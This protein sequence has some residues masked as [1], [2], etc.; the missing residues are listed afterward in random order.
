MPPTFLFQ[1]QKA[2]TFYF[3]HR[4]TQRQNKMSRAPNWCHILMISILQRPAASSWKC[5]GI[6]KNSI[7]FPASSAHFYHSQI[8]YRPFMPAL[9]FWGSVS[10]SY[11][12]KSSR[13]SNT[14]PAT[15]LLSCSL[16]PGTSWSWCRSKWLR[17]ISYDI[18]TINITIVYI[19]I[20]YSNNSTT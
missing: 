3:I 16:R 10:Q 5:L 13:A 8:R 15:N 4:T 7:E 18:T 12:V 14:N 1:G 19:H 9:I 6:H 17:L 2:W 20:Y 11:S